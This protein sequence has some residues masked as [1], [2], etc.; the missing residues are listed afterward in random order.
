MRV[1]PNYVNNLASAIGTSAAREQTLTDELSSG[2][3]VGSLSDDPV[4]ASAN[5]GLNSALSRL[6]SFV[7]SSSGVQSQLQVTDSALGEVVTQVTSALSLAISAT[8]G[9]LSSENLSAISKQLSDIRDSVVSLA[10]TTYQGTYVFAGSQG[11]TKPF[12]VDS[13][14]TPATTTYNGDTTTQTIQTPDGQSVQTNVAGSAIFTATGADLLGTLNQLVAD[15]ASGSTADISADSS[16]LTTAL[17][18]VS[19]ERSTIGSSLNRLTVTSGYAQTQRA[20]LE[21]RQSDLLSA[22]PEA[23]ASDLKTAEVQHQALLSVESALSQTN[24]FSYL[25]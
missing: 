4:A 15:A 7:H 8:N 16:A 2:L 25:K 10:N 19:T 18:N 17:A 13:T 14:T 24:L 23:V 20:Q 6:D 9:T 1:D 3:R 11:S 22:A 5:V 21:A 12:T